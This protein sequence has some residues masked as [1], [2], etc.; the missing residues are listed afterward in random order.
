MNTLR[1]GILGGTFDPI[2]Y[3]HLAVAEEARVQLGLEPVVFVPAAQPPHK[4]GRTITAVHHRM[5]M[6][7][8]ALASNPHFAISPVDVERPGPAYTVD[9]LALFQDE[10]GPK[11][12]LY[13][14]VGADS[15]L[16]M[17][18]WYEPQRIIELAYLAVAPRPL[19]LLDMDELENRLPGVAPRIRRV[20][21]PRLEISSTDLRERVRTGQSIK[22]YLPEAI[23]QYILEHG[24]YREKD[25]T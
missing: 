7:A 19:H 22:Y 15:L 14:I 4:L 21:A 25:E 9:T 13:F 5:A 2:H 17:H 24:L 23:E 11:A 16:E 20:N 1:V 10:W 8:L 12:E 3:A 18:T 6:L